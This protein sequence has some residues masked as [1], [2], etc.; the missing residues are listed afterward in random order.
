MYLILKGL[1]RLDF[2]WPEFKYIVLPMNGRFSI[3]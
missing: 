1:R 2:A 3:T